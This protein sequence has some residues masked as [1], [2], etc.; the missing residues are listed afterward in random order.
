P[1][2]DTTILSSTGAGCNH[3]THV[4]T[5]LPYA[6][7]GAGAALLGY[8]TFSITGSGLIG[9]G[10]VLAVLIGLTVFVRTRLPLIA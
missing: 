1:I 6:L 7:A 3:I 4:N 10:I 5:Q 9:L 2:S 8:I